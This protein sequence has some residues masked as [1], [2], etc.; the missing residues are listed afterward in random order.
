[1]AREAATGKAYLH[2]HPDVSGRPVIVVRAA[3]H[4]TGA[5]S[6]PLQPGG[7]PSAE[8]LQASGCFALLRG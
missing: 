4:V 3:K 8:L 5:R 6:P 7:P 2:S 1:V